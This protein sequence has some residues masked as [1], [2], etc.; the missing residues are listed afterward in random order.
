MIAAYEPPAARGGAGSS[1]ARARASAAPRRR[2]ASAGTAID[3]EADG[4]D[5]DGAH[6][7]ADLAEPAEHRGGPYGG[8]DSR[9]WISRTTCIRDRCEQSIRNYDPCISCST[10]FLKLSVHRT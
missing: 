3:F 10:H 2:A 6:R 1:R 9:C 4:I 7:A 8:R 5:R